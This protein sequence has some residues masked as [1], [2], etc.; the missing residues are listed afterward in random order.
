MDVHQIRVVAE[1]PTMWP[2]PVVELALAAA[3]RELDKRESHAAEVVRQR[4][5]E[6]L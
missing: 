6:A 3:L 1:D 2:R 4:M 5:L